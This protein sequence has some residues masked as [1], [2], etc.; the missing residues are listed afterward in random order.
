ML[1]KLQ[2]SNM[3]DFY[4]KI[5]KGKK[6]EYENGSSMWEQGSMMGPSIN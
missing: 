3:R 4:I 2:H 1:P 6:N 5:E